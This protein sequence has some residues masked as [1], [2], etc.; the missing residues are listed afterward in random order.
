VGRVV[1]TRPEPPPEE[2]APGARPKLTPDE[3]RA[4]LAVTKVRASPLK[5]A[6]KRGG[7]LVVPTTIAGI[8]LDLAFGDWGTIA[9]LVVIGAGIFWSVRPLFA[10][11]RADW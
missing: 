1:V 2:P 10:K 8:V 3:V 9:L 6:A 7:I 11:D 4:L 5:R